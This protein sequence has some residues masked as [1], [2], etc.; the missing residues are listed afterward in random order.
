LKDEAARV[1]G[2]GGSEANEANEAEEVKIFVK[3]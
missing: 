3:I 1:F 2:V